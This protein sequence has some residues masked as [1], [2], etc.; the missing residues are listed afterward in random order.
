[1]KTLQAG[2]LWSRPQV[3]DICTAASGRTRTVLSV[4]YLDIGGRAIPSKVAYEEDGG[5]IVTCEAIS[6]AHWCRR[7]RSGGGTYSRREEP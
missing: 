5:R 1:M 4:S 7:T 3:G 2:P 6:W